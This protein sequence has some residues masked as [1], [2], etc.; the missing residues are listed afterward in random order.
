MRRFFFDI[1]I[2]G[3][4]LFVV[5]IVVGVEIEEFWN[6]VLQPYLDANALS[7][8]ATMS[9]LLSGFCGGVVVALTTVALVDIAFGWAR[10]RWWPTETDR[11]QAGLD[12]IQRLGERAEQF[13]RTF[14]DKSTPSF[15]RASEQKDLIASCREL[16]LEFD[17]KA[18]FAY[19]TSVAPPLREGSLERA[20]EAARNYPRPANGDPGKEP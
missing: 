8:V 19:L 14:Q 11:R 15:L 20:K 7:W 6:N 17:G 12:K 13:V 16:G 5:R 4:L 1:L 2:T 10:R 3:L 18:P 9:E